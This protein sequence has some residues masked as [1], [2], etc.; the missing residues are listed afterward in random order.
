VALLE[1]LF[2]IYVVGHMVVVGIVTRYTLAGK[3]SLPGLGSSRMSSVGIVTRYTLAGKNS[4][5]GLG[6]IFSSLYLLDLFRSP[7]SLLSNGTMVLTP[8]V[9]LPWREAEHLPSS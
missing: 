4:V 5:P 2:L 8:G 3:D 6:S 1:N 9:N 7:P